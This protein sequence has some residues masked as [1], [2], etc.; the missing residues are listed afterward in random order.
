MPAKFESGETQTSEA[1]QWLQAARQAW[2]T[3]D[4]MT[5]VTDPPGL[6]LHTPRSYIVYNL[7]KNTAYVCTSVPMPAPG[8]HRVYALDIDTGKELWP[9]PF[10]VR[11]HVHVGASWLVRIRA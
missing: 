3:H 4:L 2:L 10:Q 7:T 1:C 9:T 5:D 6:L 8:L 11:P